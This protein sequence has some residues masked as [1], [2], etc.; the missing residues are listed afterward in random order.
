MGLLPVAWRE[1]LARERCATDLLDGQTLDA[2]DG[3]RLPDR[4]LCRPGPVVDIRPSA[5]AGREETQRR[6]DC[7]KRLGAEGSTVEDGERNG[8]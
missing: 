7:T 6:Q 1:Q 5:A 4:R 2:A 3:F 8:V